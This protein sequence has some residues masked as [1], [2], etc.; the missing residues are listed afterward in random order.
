MTDLSVKYKIPAEVMVFVDDGFL[1]LLA[2][3]EE[4]KTVE[5]HI[6]SKRSTDD[7]GR[8]T[9]YSVVWTHPD[10]NVEFG[11]YYD[12]NSGSN[13]NFHVEIDTTDVGSDL[14]DLESV[15]ELVTWLEEF[16]D[17]KT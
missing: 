4:K 17:A 14:V 13:P 8:I 1:V 12:E 3:D 16:Q 6:P 10:F 9:S 7:E 5:F 15:E 2:E 11:R